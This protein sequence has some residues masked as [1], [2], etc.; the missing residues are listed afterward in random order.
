MFIVSRYM[1]HITKGTYTSGWDG[2]IKKGKGVPF[3]A[4]KTYKR[5]RH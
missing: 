3:H 5:S 2:T 1:P 4:K